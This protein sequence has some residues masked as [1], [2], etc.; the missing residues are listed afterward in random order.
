MTRLQPLIFSRLKPV[1]ELN[2]M[3]NFF[4]APFITLLIYLAV[5]APAYAL[6]RD[7]VFPVAG[8]ASFRDDFHEPRGVDGTREHLGI[9]II[10]DKMTPIVAAVDGTVTY[11]A[12]PQPSWGYSITIRDSEGYQYRYLHINNDTPGTDDGLGGPEN[13]YYAGIKRGSKV[14]KGQ[15]VAWVGDSGN[16]EGTVSHLH[17]EIRDSNRA[18]I[19]PYDSLVAAALKNTSGLISI[20]GVSGAVQHPS[21]G[22]QGLTTSSI[23]IFTEDLYEGSSGEAV[24]QLQLRLQASGHFTS[25]IGDYFGPLTT[26]AVISYQKSRNIE[27]TGKVGLATRAALNEEAI[28]ASEAVSS[29]TGGLSEGSRGEAVVQLQTRL[30]ELGYFTSY[31]TDYFGPITKAAVIAFQ[32]ANGIDPIGI[33]GPKTSAALALDPTTPVTPPATP[34]AGTKYIFTQDLLLGARGEAV[35]QLQTKLKEL[36]YFTSYVT[37]YFGP[38]TQAAVINFQRAKGIDPIGIVGPKTRAVLNAL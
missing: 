29:S 5:S 12:I 14:V 11:V 19:N 34:P 7:I 37:D 30:K 21:E 32:I 10:A 13:A 3:L 22:E 2:K 28:L 33:V 38:I 16:A 24:R 4:S 27:P 35:R 17:F 20:G 25:P 8:K 36:G 31:I 23:Y 15:H 6:V 18:T 1:A 26:A 9:D